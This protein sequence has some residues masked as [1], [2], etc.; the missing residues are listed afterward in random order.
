[1]ASVKRLMP[2]LCM[3]FYSDVPVLTKNEFFQEL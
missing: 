1:M 2:F 3:G